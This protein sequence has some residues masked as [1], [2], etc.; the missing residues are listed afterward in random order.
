MITLYWRYGAWKVHRTGCNCKISVLDE[1]HGT[2]A[3]EAE[4]QK[5]WENR[6]EMGTTTYQCLKEMRNA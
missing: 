2:Y 3:T 5:V 1:V 6:N 4:A